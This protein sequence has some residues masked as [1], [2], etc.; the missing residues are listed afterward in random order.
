MSTNGADG[1]L[2]RA[3]LETLAREPTLSPGEI[4]VSVRDGVV[5]LS[6]YVGTYP[7]KCTA[8][9]LVSNVVGVGAVADEV[10][11]RVPAAFGASDTDLARLLLDALSSELRIPVGSVKIT[12]QDGWITLKGNVAIRDQRTAAERA[13]YAL[14]GVVGLSNLIEAPAPAAPDGPPTP[15]RA[16][17]LHAT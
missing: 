11:V 14:P 3:V 2:R 5:T 15:P 7:E 16:R 13:A 8:L 12:V 9:D 6:G 4:A 10:R 1:E 17:S